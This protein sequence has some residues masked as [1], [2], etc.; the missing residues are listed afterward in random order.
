MDQ[1]I[2]FL[3]RENA[4]TMMQMDATAPRIRAKIA[5]VMGMF[6]S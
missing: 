5:G 2:V 6:R 1:R 3:L 4:V